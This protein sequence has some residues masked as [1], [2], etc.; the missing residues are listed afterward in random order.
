MN[1]SASKSTASPEV[2]L[3]PLDDDLIHALGFSQDDLLA[4][5]TWEMPFGK[6]AGRKLITL[7][8]E[9]LFWF[10]AQ[11]FPENRLGKLMA[12]CLEL[13]IEGLDNLLKPLLKPAD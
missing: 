9:Y 4:L 1:D 5:T 2:G 12:L 3:E 7:P 6:Y 10:R 11:G 13:K 8:E